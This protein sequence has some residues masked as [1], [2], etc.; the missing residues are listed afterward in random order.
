ME[1]YGYH[2]R[3]KILPYKIF[4]G[5]G[6]DIYSCTSYCCKG[7]SSTLFLQQQHICA[8]L[9]TKTAKGW[10]K[11]VFN[12][13][14]SDASILWPTGKRNAWL[15]ISANVLTNVR[16]HWHFYILTSSYTD[17]GELGLEV[18]WVFPLKGVEYQCQN[19]IGLV[20][21]LLPA[22]FRYHTPLLRHAGERWGQVDKPM[23]A[24]LN[25]PPCCRHWCQDSHS[26]WT[27][28]QL[29]ASW[30][31]PGP[32]GEFPSLLLSTQKAFLCFPLI[33][34]RDYASTQ[35]LYH[36][37]L[38]TMEIRWC[39]TATLLRLL[40]GHCVSG[41]QSHSE[42]LTMAGWLVSDWWTSC[43]LFAPLI[44]IPKHS[45]RSVYPYELKSPAQGPH[46]KL[47]PTYPFLR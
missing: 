38:L 43:T 44:A 32:G 27:L 9:G 25:T 40:Q 46:G 23:S 20:P 4:G 3:F 15:F 11:E 42:H 24:E 16:K 33:F 8:A 31:I 22:V 1:N 17:G 12:R 41:S 21:P 39:D 29:P 47:F 10:G 28:L 6:H 37:Q 18:R 26:V 7:S 36:T 13:F 2:N 34:P 45:Q 35:L 14:L 5:D 30:A 19:R